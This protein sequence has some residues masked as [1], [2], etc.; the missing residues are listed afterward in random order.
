MYIILALGDENAIRFTSM[1]DFLSNAN[2]L[3]H[4]KIR[5]EEN[6]LPTSGSLSLFAIAFNLK[7]RASTNRQFGSYINPFAAQISDSDNRKRSLIT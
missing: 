1:H 3:P 7:L 2:R 5:Q 6:S 4:T